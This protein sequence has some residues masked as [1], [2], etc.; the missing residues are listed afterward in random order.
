MAQD[1][2]LHPRQRML[3]RMLLIAR[4]AQKAKVG[5]WNNYWYFMYTEDQAE[6]DMLVKAMGDATFGAGLYLEL[7]KFATENEE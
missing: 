6:L 1:G 2:D 5:R 4:T 7:E 3:R